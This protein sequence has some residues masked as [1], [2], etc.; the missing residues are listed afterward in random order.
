MGGGT[1]PGETLPTWLLAIGERAES[2]AVAAAEPESGDEGEPRADAVP[3]AAAL[4]RRLRAGNPAVVAR[5]ERDLV[6]CD[7]RTV[8]PDEDAGLLSALRAAWRG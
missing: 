3:S 1:L 2:A 8:L 4:A 7:P 5:V 6:L